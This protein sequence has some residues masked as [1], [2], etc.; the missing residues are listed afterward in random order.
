M[1]L[2]IIMLQL[3]KFTISMEDMLHLCKMNWGKGIMMMMKQLMKMK[4]KV[5]KNVYW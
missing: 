2:L 1:N 3:K 5:M 4:S